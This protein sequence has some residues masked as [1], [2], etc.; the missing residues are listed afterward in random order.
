MSLYLLSHGCGCP[1][2]WI[3]A[4]HRSLRCCGYDLVTLWWRQTTALLWLPVSNP[5]REPQVQLSTVV[6]IVCHYWVHSILT[7]LSSLPSSWASFERLLAGLL[8]AIP[9]WILIK[10]SF[11]ISVWL[12]ECASP[13]LCQS[14]RH[15]WPSLYFKVKVDR[16]AGIIGLIALEI[17]FEISGLI[18]HGF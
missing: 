16:Q 2:F 10:I 11:E 3:K 4:I 15:R 6:S 17:S 7:A 14:S 12:L 13:C 1:Y 5:Q 18:S 8:L 9:E